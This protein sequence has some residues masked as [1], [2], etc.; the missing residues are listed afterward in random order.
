MSDFRLRDHFTDDGTRNAVCNYCGDSMYRAGRGPKKHYLENHL[1]ERGDAI[2]ISPDMEAF[3]DKAQ[4]SEADREE[5]IS[6]LRSMVLDTK[7]TPHA[8]RINAAN[9]LSRIE[10]YEEMVGEE[11]EDEACDK[12]VARFKREIDRKVDLEEEMMDLLR[13]DS[14]ALVWMEKLCATVRAES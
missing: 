14:D 13:A 12:V 3:V 2:A 8:A 11:D 6:A 1:D 10:R 5:V 7:G 9:A 4:R